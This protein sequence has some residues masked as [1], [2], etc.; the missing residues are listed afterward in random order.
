MDHLWKHF[1]DGGWGMY[2]LVIWL[3]LASLIAA[4]RGVVLFALSRPNGRRLLQVI[5]SLLLRGEP[6]EAIQACART[7]SPASRVAMAGLSKMER[8]SRDMQ[9]AMDAAML[10]EVPL[11]NLRSSYLPVLGNLGILTGL[12]G[13]INGLTFSF[14]TVGSDSA[15][16]GQKAR[17]I[18]ERISEAM[19]CTAL[20]LI[21]AITCVIAH[22]VLQRRTQRI[23]DDIHETSVGIAGM[24]LG[25]GVLLVGRD[26]AEYHPRDV[27]TPIVPA[28]SRLRSVRRP[29][30]C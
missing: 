15:D 26:R 24:V 27:A 13:T 2:P 18:A 17:I 1:N 20:G 4:E 28:G 6:F 12:L 25:K 23:E 29:G 16:P 10:R 11:L 7:N 19:N 14:C 3:L 5:R 30:A 9:A 8:P 21:I 22:A